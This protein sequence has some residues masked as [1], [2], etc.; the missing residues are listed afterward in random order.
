MTYA[1]TCEQTRDGRLWA[2]GFGAKGDGVADDTAALRAA[3]LALAA[4]GGGTLDLPP[5]KYLLRPTASD[6]PVIAGTTPKVRVR[7]AGEATEIQVAS[8]ALPYSHLFNLAGDGIEIEDLVVN[9]QVDQNPWRDGETAARKSF[10]I[11]GRGTRLKNVHIINSSAVSDITLSGSDIEVNNCHWRNIGDDPSHKEHDWSGIYTQSASNVRITGCSVEGAKPGAPSAHTFIEIHGSDHLVMGCSAKDVA[12]LCNLTG[13]SA[14]VDQG[15]RIIGNV[16]HG[17]MC[18]A[19]VWAAPYYE[20]PEGVGI[21]GAL[22]YGN[23]FYL[24]KAGLWG[25]GDA[26]YGVVCHPHASYG[27]HGLKVR[28]NYVEGPAEDDVAPNNSSCALGWYCSEED[29][30]S[31]EDC[32]ISHNTVVGFPMAGVRVTGVLARNVDI[33]DNQLRDCGKTQHAVNSGYRAPLFLAPAA[34]S[35]RIGVTRNRIFDSLARCEYGIHVT[36]TGSS[37]VYLRD[38]EVEA[39]TVSTAHLVGDPI[40]RGLWRNGVD[41]AA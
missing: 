31:F 22:I 9:H 13:I 38:N 40:V 28:S 1:I 3:L 7:G 37:K 32:D 14:G 26:L 8:D 5:G 15:N 25:S 17:V 34:G 29:P 21:D 10:E 11:S 39:G 12:K 27:I 41:E 33:T 4:S 2:S 19:L 6:L 18:G 36:T 30:Q 23:S 16:A 24:A 35:E 20:P